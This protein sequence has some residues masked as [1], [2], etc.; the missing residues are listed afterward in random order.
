MT[1]ERTT[2]LEINNLYASYILS[3]LLQSLLTAMKVDKKQ[4]TK[5]EFSDMLDVVTQVHLLV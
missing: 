2:V 1:T 3:R 5:I 4:Q